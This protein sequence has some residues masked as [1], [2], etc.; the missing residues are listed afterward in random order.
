MPRDLKTEED[1]FLAHQR[2]SNLNHT[3]NTAG[4][5]NREVRLR[6]SQC[7]MATLSP[8]SK[9]TEAHQNYVDCPF[10]NQQSEYGEPSHQYD[11]SL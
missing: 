7:Q 9:A 5:G 4:R 10:S 11:I 1:D 8:M 2:E 6:P 3:Q